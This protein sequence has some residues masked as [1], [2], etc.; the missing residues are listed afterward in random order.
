M[1]ARIASKQATNK[2]RK[3]VRSGDAESVSR[4]IASNAYVDQRDSEGNTP[5]MIAARLGHLDIVVQLI[6]SGGA[7][8]NRWNDDSN[9]ALTL[10]ADA[11]HRKVV[12]YLWTVAS[13]EVCQSV[14]ELSL[15][16][17][18]K[19]RRRKKDA[20]VEKLVEA[21][22]GG[23]EDVVSQLISEGVAP[24]SIS[25]E[26]QSALHLA[27]FYSRLGVMELLLQSGAS[28]D[29]LNEDEGP[30]G[31]PF[32]TPLAQVA[33]SSFAE[34][35]VEAMN[36]LLAAGANP[37]AQ[38]AYGMTPLMNA[39]DYQTG[40][41]DSVQCLLNAGAKVTLRNKEGET[42]LVIAERFQRDEILAL[43]CNS[44]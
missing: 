30:C 34:H 12:E 5:L 39:I 28:A 20:R 21:A 14:G 2:L 22:T 10:A 4:V 8:P 42:A 44:E 9:N 29:V 24:D 19:R 26:G 3:A 16:I 43:L 31:G 33:G 25:Q 41:P 35:R 40:Y 1:K 15:L 7:S 18:E 17:G 32:S 36:L 37:N 6:E 27:A 23:L 38:D 11:G 13:K